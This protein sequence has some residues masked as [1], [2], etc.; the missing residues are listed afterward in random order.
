MGARQIGIDQLLEAELPDAGERS[1]DGRAGEQEADQATRGQLVRRAWTAK[2]F[3]VVFEGFGQSLFGNIDGVDVVPKASL[4]LATLDGANGFVLRGAAP[5]DGAGR[6]VSHAGDVNNDGFDDLVVG[7][8]G[9]N[10]SAGE[11]YVVFGKESDFG[12]VFELSA[13]DGANGF[14]LA[15]IDSGDQAGR[16]VSGAGDVNGDGFDDLII[17]ARFADPHGAVDAGESYVVLGGASFAANL[18]LATLDGANGFVLNGI[19]SGDDS[20]FTVSGA[21]DFNGDGLDDLLIGARQADPDGGDSAGESYLVFGSGNGFT[22]SLDLAALDGANGIR[23]TG[24]ADDDH[25]G[26]SVSGAGDVNDDGY[27]DLLIGAVGV[28]TSAGADAGAAYVVYGYRPPIVVTNTSDSGA[29]SLRQAIL[30]ANAAPGTDTIAFDIPLTDANR[31]YYQDDGVAGALSVVASTTLAEGAIS[32]FD[33]DYPA[34]PHTWYSIRPIAKL[35]NITDPVIIDGFTQTGASENSNTVGLGLNATLTIEINGSA[36]PLNT[37]G[38]DVRAGDSIVRGIAVNEFNNGISLSSE[39]RNVV[40]GSFVGTD[41]TGTVDKGNR[42][43]GIQVVSADNR[44]GGTTAAERNLISGNELGVRMVSSGAAGNLVQGNLIGTDASG[45]Q[46]LGNT[47]RGVSITSGANSNAVGGAQTGARN[48]ISATAFIGVEISSNSSGNTVEGNFIGT[49]VTGS[50]ALGNARGLDILGPGNRIGGTAAGAGNVIS[51]N[52]STG[53]LISGS[54]ATGNVVEGNFIGT[55]AAGMLAIGNAGGV[56]ITN[57]AFDNVIGGSIAGAGNLISGN[58]GNGLSIL[59]DAT[60]NRVEGNLIGTDHTGAGALGNGSVG[61]SISGDGNTVGG[62]T[63]GAGNKIAFNDSVGV[64]I[65]NQGVGNAVLGNSITNNTLLGIDLSGNGVTANDAGDAD[66]GANNLQN[67][68]ELNSAATTSTTTV[69]GTLNSTANTTFRLEFFSNTAADVFGNGEGE[70]FL[71]AVEATTDA[72]GDASFA[73]DVGS[74]VPVG[75]LI[76]ATATDPD[77]NTSEF[78]V[79]VAVTDNTPPVADAGGDYAVDEGGAVQLDASASSDDQQDAATLTY[80]WDLDG[81]G[82]FGETGSDAHQGDETGI[83]PTFSA[84]GLDGPSSAAVALRVT[85]DGGL[86]DTAVATVDIANVAPVV[87]VNRG[88]ISSEG[89]F[90]S[91]GT[92]VDPGNDTWTVEVDYGDGT[93]LLLNLGANKSF[94]LNHTYDTT[95]SGVYRLTVLVADDDGGQDLHVGRRRIATGTAGGDQIHIVSGSTI[96]EINGVIAATIPD[97]EIDDVV[98]LGGDGDDEIVV[99][100]TISLSMEL[101]GGQGDDTITGGGGDNVIDGGDGNDTITGGTAG[102]TLIGGAGDDTLV[103]GGGTNTVIGGGGNNTFVPGSGVNTVETE[104]GS[105]TPEVFAE[106]Y[107]VA[108][109]GVLAVPAAGVLANDVDPTGAGLSAVLVSDPA[110]GSL[111]LAPDG[112]FTYTPDGDFNGSDSFKYLANN[113]SADSSEATVTIA[114]SPVNDVPLADEKSA[115]VTE[116]GAVTITL[117]ASDVE[118]DD[119]NLVFTVT[120]VPAHGVLKDADG[121][122]VDVGNSFTG[123]PTLSYEPGAAR[124]GE[125]S[126]S[127]SFTV[128]DRGDPDNGSGD[129]PLTSDPA[130]V[131]IDIAKAI[132]DGAVTV[133]PDGVVRIGGTS[134]DDVISISQSADGSTLEVIVNGVVAS[135]SP[136]LADVTEIRAWG[137]EGDDRLEVIDLAINALLHGGAGA[138]ELIGGAGSDLFFGGLGDDLLTGGAGN[139]FLIGGSEADRIIGSSGHDVLVAADV[140]EDFTDE[141]LRLVLDD[142]ASGWEPDDEDDDDLL[143]ETLGDD[144]SDKLTG[145]SGSDWFIISDGDKVTDFKKK[146]IDGDLVTII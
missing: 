80:E 75:Q 62:T 47:S 54:T 126:D 86:T 145:S 101:L 130:S 40:A 144:G 109:D 49:D 20:G 79:A 132:A 18:D 110:H 66:T 139:D 133:D 34:A 108:E 135:V 128:T 100:S 102:N 39:G 51:G 3:A 116:D 98:V 92:I 140:A 141:A 63:A 60:G 73:I 91:S 123:P 114:V 87:S 129:L 113:G 2:N 16:S 95:Q 112:S 45:T 14:A 106:A 77:G 119:A 35:P 72:G 71:T 11:S 42:F 5:G 7:A 29:G 27:A 76:T 90:T 37:T 88:Q 78:S 105:T 82:I 74:A 121:D 25:A 84:A 122:Q 89:L 117:S 41:V 118:T 44:L 30:D 67:Y 69:A 46:G 124:E 142:W 15:G 143:D 83:N 21:G 43:A 28:D 97:G 19:D 32:D 65:G 4:D 57:T 59:T 99:E 33:P 137:R 125:G 31:L 12:A 23:F 103:D 85:D 146:N 93:V 1:D 22:P 48:V 96:I 131:E 56:Q 9:A 68:P 81:D 70:T 6:S 115:A 38:L 94:S 136:P 13:L 111:V 8:F 36:A 120:S 53:L 107:L 10:S 104:P 58:T 17:G 138:D 134:V 52:N 50:A 127:F 24:T 61:V 55:N 64:N 26:T